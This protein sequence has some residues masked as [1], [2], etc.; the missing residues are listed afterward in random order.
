MRADMH[1]YFDGETTAA[2]FALG[3]GTLALGGA[4][5]GLAFSDNRY[6]EGAAWP[7]GI[8]GLIEVAAGLVLLLRTPGQVEDLDA[9]LDSDP[10]AYRAEELERME[11]VND[12]FDILA[13]AEIALM[14]IGVGI[15]TWG[16]LDD[17][18]FAVGLGI[19]MTA[20]F[21]LGFLFDLN[22]AARADTYTEQLRAF[23]P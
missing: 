2:W 20:Q 10:E 23:S 5:Y 19:G 3:V 4:T 21:L 17:E 8:V 12:Q 16:L 15:T 11:G 18:P 14:A 22:A 9:Q 13:I 6:L 7:V 1:D